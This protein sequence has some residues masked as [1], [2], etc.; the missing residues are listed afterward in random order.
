M[1]G[2]PFDELAD[3]VFALLWAQQGSEDLPGTTEQQRNPLG[4]SDVK[5]C[6]DRGYKLTATRIP[7]PFSKFVLVFFF[8]GGG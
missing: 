5:K 3:S 1:N 2:N 6:S 7:Y 8:W 4:I